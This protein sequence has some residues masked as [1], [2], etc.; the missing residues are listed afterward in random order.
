MKRNFAELLKFIFDSI[1]KIAK[2][3]NNKLFSVELPKLEK[4][5]VVQLDTII[6]HRVMKKYLF[7]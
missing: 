3:R 5:I 2:I 4:D 6:L 7:F 1:T